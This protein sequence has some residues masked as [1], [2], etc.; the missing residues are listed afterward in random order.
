M[1]KTKTKKKSSRAPRHSHKLEAPPNAFERLHNKKRF[2]ILGRKTKGDTRHVG[3]LRSAA[4]QKRKDTLLIEYKQLGK[5]N[6][7][8][9]R[10]FGEDDDTLT[11]EEKALLR[12]QKQRIKDASGGRFSLQDA[13]EM[14]GNGN[15]GGDQYEL[16]HLGRSLADDLTD[17]PDGWNSDDDGV[18]IDPK[19]EA[20][21]N[22]G[23]G[24][25]QRKHTSD[26]HHDYINDDNDS[27]NN[28][29]H[30]HRTKKEIMEEVI[31]K[32]KA[33][34][35]AKREQR[36]DDINETDKLDADFQS[37]LDDDRSL[38]GL[39][40]KKGEGGGNKKIPIIGGGG[41]GGGTTNAVDD[42]KRFDVLA[43][44]LVFEAK[45]RPGER[46]PTADELAEAEHRRLKAA[47]TAQLKRMQHGGGGGGE[48]EDGSEDE[49]V[50]EE[51]GGRA[52]GGYAARRAKRARAE[53]DDDDSDF[54]ARRKK[55][56]NINSADA[57]EDDFDLDDDSDGEGGSDGEEDGLLTALE[58]RRRER[59]GGDHPL[60]QTFKEAS[61]KLLAKY[62]ITVDGE[63]EEREDDSDEEVEDD[64]EEDSSS[65]EEEET[66][67]SSEEEEEEEEDAA[68]AVK[69]SSTTT[70]EK[71]KTD[72][73][74]EEEEL[75]PTIPFTPSLPGSY[76]DFQQLA[77]AL[78]PSDLN[79]LVRRIRVCNAAAL[80]TGNRKA[81][82]M[83]YGILVQHFANLSSS[84]PKSSSS[85]SA[86]A[87]AGEHAMVDY[88]NDLLPHILEMTPLVPF[89]AAALARARLQR[90]HETMVAALA[91]PI[92]KARAWPVP[93]TLALLKLFATVFPVSDKRHAV[94]TP[95]S[96]LVTSALANCPL[97]RGRDVGT[98]L[99]LA[100]M[101]VHLHSQ[102]KRYCPEPL[103]FCTL[104]L[105]SIVAFGE[106]EEQ[107]CW[108][109][110]VTNKDEDD[111]NKKKKNSCDDTASPSEVVAAPLSLSDILQR[112]STS[113]D[114]EEASWTSTAFKVSA[115]AAA[116]KI[117][118]RCAELWSDIDAA[119]EIFSSSVSILKKIASSSPSSSSPF[120]MVKT[121][122]A[123]KQLA[124]EAV[125]KLETI[126]RAAISKRRPLINPSLSKAPE[127]KS[128]NPRFE[129]DFATGKDYDPDRER[130]E[131]RKLQKMV[132]REERGAIRELRRDASFMADVRDREKEKKQGELDGSARR[133]MAF[134][135]QQ[136][137]DFKSGGQ[138]GMWKKK[139]RK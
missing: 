136:E 124:K 135:Q 28:N 42:D 134:L 46:A 75:Q 57:L 102:A 131:R 50:F 8:L 93:R 63:E 84:P 16:T 71:A 103:V 65:S 26:N 105:E 109:A 3:R 1:G 49:G 19:L 51:G 89:Y 4:T 107:P 126:T 128:F 119:P 87:A 5:A 33:Y 111:K 44:E 92:Q 123:I 6:A 59:A 138:G 58:M 82:Q 62:G 30:R 117:I 61:A 88:L 45:S 56:R 27:N 64:E 2:D 81:M 35:A 94:F 68:A 40:K 122:P 66:S 80:S 73:K 14:N 36:E 116:I 129:D 137:A 31:A 17:A 120:S 37:L 23:G 96:L 24:F 125:T 55:T 72:N 7:F 113:T 25:F 13:D 100:G 106:E 10:R 9:D 53:E 79:E 32:S 76:E 48:D 21:L 114:E 70:T 101:A 60:Q 15:G 86:A 133:A 121:V 112:L 108:L 52:K 78:S 67:S 77:D 54:D 74:G 18:F 91:D 11:A 98:G 90:A 12:F 43:K 38:L 132:R 69:A 127:A 97:A 47:E 39:M 110:I 115:S 29:N 118:L 95:A 41:G 34:K 104:L 20:D 99:Y 83:F 22:F 130:S 85:S 139:K